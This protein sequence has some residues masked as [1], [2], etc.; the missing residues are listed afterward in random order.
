MECEEDTDFV[1]EFEN[2]MKNEESI[3]IGGVKN[4]DLTVPIGINNMIAGKEA[5]E[6][7]IMFALV[8]RK[9]TKTNVQAL[10]V[11]QVSIFNF[12]IFLNLS[13]KKY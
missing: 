1:K 8:T 10:Q 2:L 6:G 9:G 3:S 5:K 13:R 12:R 7:Q 4:A 11:P